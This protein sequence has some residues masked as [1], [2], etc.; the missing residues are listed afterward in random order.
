[1]M[2]L[3]KQFHIVRGVAGTAPAETRAV[4]LKERLEAALRTIEHGAVMV[5]RRTGAAV[6]LRQIGDADIE[7]GHRFELKG[8]S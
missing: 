7:G 3:S 6:A 4:I 1:M 8:V 2:I 5:L